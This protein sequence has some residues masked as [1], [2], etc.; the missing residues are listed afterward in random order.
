MLPDIQHTHDYSK[1]FDANPNQEKSLIM[2]DYS[3]RVKGLR[4]AGQTPV[5][6]FKSDDGHMEGTFSHLGKSGIATDSV[7]IHPDGRGKGSYRKLLK[8]L[9]STFGSVHSSST[10]SDDAHKAWKSV[11]AAQ[12]GETYSL[13]SESRKKKKSKKAPLRGNPYGPGR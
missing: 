8:G 6:H 12:D 7:R 4:M 3:V 9:A 11:G 5:Y 1:G 2:G 13:Y 10:L